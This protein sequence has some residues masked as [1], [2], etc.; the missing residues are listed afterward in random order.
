MDVYVKAL[1]YVYPR[2]EKIA[3]DYEEHVKNKAYFSF[4]SRTDTATLAEY[5][6][7]EIIK[8][9]KVEEIEEIMEKIVAGLSADERVLLEMRYFRRKNVMRK[10]IRSGLMKDKTRTYFRRQSRL[11]QKVREKLELRGLS[12]ENF[13]LRYGEIE[14]F[15]SVCKYVAEGKDKLY[16]AKERAML[17][18]LFGDGSQNFS[19]AQGK[20]KLPPSV[21]RS[22]ERRA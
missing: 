7:G 5:L 9:R 21:K 18:S 10:I 6:A 14:C 15:A 13:F 19:S 20:R 1:L 16:A 8:K 12:E 11:L 3:S 4:L 22:R 2:L 17:L